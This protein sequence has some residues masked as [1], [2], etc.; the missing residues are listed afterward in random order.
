MLTWNKSFDFAEVISAM[1]A[2]PVMSIEKYFWKTLPKENLS[3]WHADNLKN[4]KTQFPDKMFPDLQQ[5]AHKRPRCETKDQ[6]LQTLTTASG[7]IWSRARQRALHPCEALATHMLPVTTKQSVTCGSPS[8]AIQGISDNQ[9][10][11]MAGNCMNVCNMGA[12]ILACLFC[13]DAN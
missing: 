5:N 11:K 7:K 8:L 6:C 4:Y 1:K 3:G 2:R 13:L 12:V 10:T 9:L